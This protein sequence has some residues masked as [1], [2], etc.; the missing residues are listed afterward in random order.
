MRPQRMLTGEAAKAL[1]VSVQRIRQLVDAGRLPAV[2]TETGVRLLDRTAV[3]DLAARR[4]LE[5][6]SRDRTAVR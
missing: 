1:G 5:K 6:T 2:R 3:E 4:K